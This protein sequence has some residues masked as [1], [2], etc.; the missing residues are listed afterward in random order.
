MGHTGPMGNKEARLREALTEA[1]KA[2]DP[3]ARA[4]IRSALGAIDNAR[5]VRADRRAGPQGSGPIAGSVE[6]L[7][8]GEASRRELDEGQITEIVRAEVTSREAAAAEYERLGRLDEAARL[9]AECG[10][11]R[12]LLHA[13]APG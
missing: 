13:Q 10:V 11:L 2:R 1:M 5:S 3:I 7:G 9:R 4:A 12:R 6:G 8:A